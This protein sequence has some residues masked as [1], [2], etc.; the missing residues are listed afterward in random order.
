MPYIMCACNNVVP[1]SWYQ[2]AHLLCL[3]Q[4][5]FRL[6]IHGLQQQQQ[7]QRDVDQGQAAAGQPLMEFI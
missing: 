7:Q 4:V 6:A 1:H 2:E 3:L 5:L